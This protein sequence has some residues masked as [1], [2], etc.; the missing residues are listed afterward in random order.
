MIEHAKLARDLQHIRVQPETSTEDTLTHFFSSFT[1]IAIIS[2]AS[3]IAI[4]Y[5][6]GIVQHL[7][8]RG[9]RLDSMEWF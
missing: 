4:G 8:D 2:L 9:W 3:G 6:I 7:A 5:S 1:E